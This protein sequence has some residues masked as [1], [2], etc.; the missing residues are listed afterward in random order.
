[1][2]DRQG[3]FSWLW[4]KV[5]GICPWRCKGGTRG[6]DGA[7]VPEGQRPSRG[8][9]RLA[10]SMSSITEILCRAVTLQAAAL[11]GL[12]VL[13]CALW[14]LSYS[15]DCWSLEMAYT[16]LS[17]S[18]VCPVS[19]A[20]QSRVVCWRLADEVCITQSISFWKHRNSYWKKTGY[21]DYLWFIFLFCFVLYLLR[22][23]HHVYV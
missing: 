16:W 5:M 22:S 17:T 4:K 8:S 6:G 18:C 3:G 11:R 23:S 12:L 14:S 19:C 21:K 1:M 10:C 20:W 2:E 15:G 13:K 9:Q 7:W